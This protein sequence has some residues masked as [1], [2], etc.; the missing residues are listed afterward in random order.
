MSPIPPLI[1]F[2]CVVR[3]ASGRHSPR[4]DRQWP[5]TAGGSAA[6]SAR[7]VVCALLLLAARPALAG[8]LIVSQ[9]PEYVASIADR[10]VGKAPAAGGHVGSIAGQKVALP[11]VEAMLDEVLPRLGEMA[12]EMG[13]STVVAIVPG[14]AASDASL[15]GDIVLASRIYG[16]EGDTPV[17]A[18]R[19]L[20]DA[21]RLAGADAGFFEVPDARPD[22]VGGRA[23]LVLIAPVG[24]ASSAPVAGGGGVAGVSAGTHAVAR[25]LASSGLRWALI[26]PLVGVAGEPIGEMYAQRAVGNVS[27]LLLSYLKTLPSPPPAHV[28]DAPRTIGKGVIGLR[29]A[30]DAAAP[31]TATFRRGERY[32]VLE[33]TP[34][35]T[36]NRI[37]LLDG[38]AGW[39]L[40]STLE[41]EPLVAYELA[42]E[43]RFEVLT[44]RE[45]DVSTQ[46]ANPAFVARAVCS[47]N[48]PRLAKPR[49]HEAVPFCAGIDSFELVVDTVNVFLGPKSKS[50]FQGSNPDDVERFLARLV[51][52]LTEIGRIHVVRLR[53]TTAEPPFVP[54][55]LTRDDF[56]TYWPTRDLERAAE[57][58]PSV[59]A[60]ERAR[61]LLVERRGS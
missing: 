11:G 5:R 36:W 50:F 15:Q 44:P 38:R 31:V 49:G 14:R 42:R 60:R 20:I 25:A 34:D 1:A 13:C 24:M 9:D 35:E 45:F 46:D 18:E 51:Y 26:Q 28:A 17:D 57:G 52:S 53:F 55:L 59:G 41:R 10:L 54:R 8:V 27:R 33:T 12:A 22:A 37:Q 58:H 19:E 48:D 32:Q 23:P 43:G 29:D 3:P 6:R 39:A 56:M 4:R 7:L 21:I 16:A 2:G 47:P 61:A 30:P 40:G